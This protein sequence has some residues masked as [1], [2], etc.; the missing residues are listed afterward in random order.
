MA[1]R[2]RAFT[3]F[4]EKEAK[5]ALARL[6]AF[7]RGRAGVVPVE[8]AVVASLVAGAVFVAADNMGQA[9]SDLFMTI[10]EAI[11]QLR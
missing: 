5:R 3:M 8:Y 1:L 4:K 9:I 2:E 10:A 11:P 6:S 7:G